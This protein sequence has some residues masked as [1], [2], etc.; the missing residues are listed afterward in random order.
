MKLI[1]KVLNENI[2]K[3]TAL[4]VSNKRTYSIEIETPNEKDFK[5]AKELAKAEFQHGEEYS[6]GK[7]LNR[8]YGEV[9][10]VGRY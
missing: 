10:S 2:P 9:Y 8:F 7:I 1:G 3:F 5:L 6:G 4:I